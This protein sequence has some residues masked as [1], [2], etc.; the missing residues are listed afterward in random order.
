MQTRAQKARANEHRPF[1]PILTSR[2]PQLDISAGKLAKLQK[3]DDTLKPL[4]MLVGSTKQQDS[5]GSVSFVIRDGLLYRGL[6]PKKSNEVI[7]QLVVPV[8]LRESVLIC[9]HDGLLGGHM[10]LNS[11]FKRVTRFFFWPGYRQSIKNYCRSC[12]ICQKTY[13]KGRVAPAPLQPLP[14][15]DVPFSRVCI[16]LIGPIKPASTRGHQ[17]ILTLV[18]VAT[19]YPEAIALRSITTEAVAEALLEI[20]ART[21]L[22]DEIL[23]DLGTQFTSDLMR[24]ILRLLSVSQLHSTPYHPQTNGIVE[25]FNG[26]LKTMLRKLMAD[27]PR[28]WDRYLGPALF[29]YREIPQE[30]TGFSPFELLYGRVPRG[31]AELLYYSWTETKRDTEQV[32][33]SEYV[34]NL[35]TV[36][37]EMA[38]RAQEAVGTTSSKNKKYKPGRFRS[39]G[40]GKQVLVLLPSDHNK[41]ILRWRGPFPV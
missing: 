4:F 19:R 7:W 32:Q 34:E 35:K 36:L 24:E 2:A 14:M 40:E 16:D 27:K 38:S 11:T 17:Y 25:R 28:D 5:S 37:C 1:R 30:S 12:A 6:C 22:P 13:P 15:V 8:S 21:G 10:G 18:D 39:I 3:V 26:T 33:A 29:A 9:T 20:F 31:P 41:M 23:S